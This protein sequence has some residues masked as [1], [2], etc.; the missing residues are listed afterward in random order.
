MTWEEVFKIVS[1]MLFSLGGG[2]AIV[3]G[4]SS[5]LGK[6]WA[7]RILQYEQSQ[8]DKLK[9]DYENELDKLKKEHEVK[10]SK[11]HSEKAEAIKEIAQKLDQLGDSW[12]SIL[13]DIQDHPG[14]PCREEKINELVIIHNEYR[15]LYKKN[16]I[17][18]K[19]ETAQLMHDIAI[20]SRDT[21]A[22]VDAEDSIQRDIIIM[23]KIDDEGVRKVLD[24][25][26]NQKKEFQK[27]AKK[28]SEED[29]SRLIKELETTFRQLL[30]VQ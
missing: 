23:E 19:P 16:K 21:K 4:L 15:Q 28:R 12:H 13:K 10:F 3:W 24:N 26:K 14:E 20:A 1:S 22:E 9:K 7:G 17:F 11:L 6:I 5:Y 30:G 18:F 25:L 29:F 27:S 8:L 2:G